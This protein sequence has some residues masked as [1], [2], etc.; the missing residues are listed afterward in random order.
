MLTFDQLKAK[1]KPPANL[2]KSQRLQRGMMLTLILIGCCYK[3]QRSP[4]IYSIVQGW[5]EQSKG[6]TLKELFGV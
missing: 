2:S 1:L 6:R 3:L 4:F 5:A